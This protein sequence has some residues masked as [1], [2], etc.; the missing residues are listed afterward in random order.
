MIRSLILGLCL[1]ALIAPAQGANASDPTWPCVQRKV[2][3]LS[4][5]LM[6][7]H[8]ID[9]E[10]LREEIAA[11]AVDLAA[12]L[13]LRRVDLDEAR[14]L[15]TQFVED[16]PDVTQADLGHLFGRI[17]DEINRD[18][19]ALIAGIEDYAE[20][21]I[22]LANRIDEARS[23][24]DSLAA[25]ATPDQEAIASLQQQ[26]AWDERVFQDRSQSLTYVCETPVLLEQRL[27][28]IAQLL[29]DQTPE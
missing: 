28:A 25:A 21:Q 20:K 13:E 14:T 24:I 12:K 27:Y 17:F 26:I 7:P 9:A 19:R 22:A 10:P 3:S 1:V 2:Q 16:H 23:K 8:P 4:L 6:W 15:I 29:L 18:R 11:D 5:G